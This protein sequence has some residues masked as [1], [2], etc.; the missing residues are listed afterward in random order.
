MKCRADV[1][2]QCAVAGTRGRVYVSAVGHGRRSA[3]FYLTEEET[4]DLRSYYKKVR[5]AEATLTGE[6][7]VW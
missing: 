1:A 7:F 3:P 2:I 5:E 4:M 6:H